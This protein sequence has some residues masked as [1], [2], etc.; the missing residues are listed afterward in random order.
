VKNTIWTGTFASVI[1][2]A[3]ATALMA[4]APAAPQTPASPQAP[5]SQQT[6]ATPQADT[7]SEKKVIVTGCLRAAP[8]SS[9]TAGTTGSAATPGATGT[10]GT[11][12]ST[13]TAPTTGSADQKFVLTDAAPADPS[14][15]ANTTDATAAGTARMSYRLVANPAAL[16]PHVGKKLELTGTLESPNSASQDSTSG[17]EATMPMLRVASGKIVAAACDEK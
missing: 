2:C 10:A 6:P 11:P 1:A 7:S 3:A 14:A 9:E 13:N 16:S 5:T 4:Q 15:A 12:G 8:S 17:P